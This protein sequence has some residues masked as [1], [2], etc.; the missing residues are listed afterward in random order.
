[1]T[2]VDMSR[3]RGACL[4]A[5]APAAMGEAPSQAFAPPCGGKADEELVN[6]MDKQSCLM[7]CFTYLELEPK[8]LLF[9]TP[10]MPTPNFEARE[11][12]AQWL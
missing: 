3:T 10:T 4:A 2:V 9:F 5:G 1:M 6:I 12:A 8:W 11:M 7:A